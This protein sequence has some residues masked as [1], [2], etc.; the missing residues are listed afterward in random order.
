[1]NWHDYFTYDTETGNLIWKERPRSSFNSDASWNVH[2]SKHAGRVA[3]N[4][5]TPGY[6]DVCVCF[7]GEKPRT[8]K[9]HRVI[10]EMVHGSIPSGIQ[11]DHING[12]RDD[13][14]VCN[15]RLATAAQNSYNKKRGRRGSSRFKGV[16]LTPYGGGTWLATITKNR[17]RKRIG[18]YATPEEAAAAYNNE[19]KRLH[20]EF[21]KLNNINDTED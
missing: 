10:W 16:H 1:M 20:M 21:S 17:V 14:R 7:P 4:H 12:I 15:L 13:N 3:G 9:S 11:V 19:A 5:N 18:R 2:R 6:I 8:F